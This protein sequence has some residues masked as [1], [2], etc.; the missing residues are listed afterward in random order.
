MAWVPVV[1]GAILASYGDSAWNHLGLAVW[2]IGLGL[3]FASL[4]LFLGLQRR[5]VRESAGGRTLR[6]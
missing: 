3:Q 6:R 5:T 1:V 2:T 4:V